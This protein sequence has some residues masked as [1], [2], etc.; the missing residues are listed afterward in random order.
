MEGVGIFILPSRFQSFEVS[1]PGLRA[2]N[3]PSFIA[4]LF[5]SVFLFSCRVSL[6]VLS[7]RDI[8]H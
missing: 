2:A 4:F 6:P 3:F 5:L 7:N 8:A 1:Q